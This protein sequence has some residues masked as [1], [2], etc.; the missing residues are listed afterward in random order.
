[1]PG[2]QIHVKNRPGRG[3]VYEEVELQNVRSA[4]TI[5][6]RIV[7][8]KITD[9]ER[10]LSII[11]AVPVVQDDPQWRCRTWVSQALGAIARDGACV[12]TAMLDW[13]EIEPTAREYA[14]TKAGTGRFV[15]G[16]TG[17]PKPTWDMLARKELVP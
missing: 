10:L 8:A 3:W 5:L 11:R 7:I 12:G 1:M 13:A 2:K 17:L 9:E 16:D 6:V 15:G 4:V 14:A